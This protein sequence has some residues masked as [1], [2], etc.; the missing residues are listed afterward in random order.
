MQR[1]LVAAQ[2]CS[3]HKCCIMPWQRYAC[4]VSYRGSAYH[5]WQA[6][7]FQPDVPTVA[8]SVQAAFS[9]VFG[10]ANV[11]RVAGASRTDAGVH[12]LH[13]VFHV[14]VCRRLK[15]SG[16]E[17]APLPPH[18]LQA[19]VN[20]QLARAGQAVVL[21]GAT[22]VSAEFHARAHARM[23]T[24]VYSMSAP[25]RCDAIA[26]TPANELPSSA[27]RQGS[28]AAV[29]VDEP[30]PGLPEAPQDEAGEEAHGQG[31]RA[32]GCQAGQPHRRAEGTRSATR[33]AGM[34]QEHRHWKGSA[35]P[36]PLVD[37]FGPALTWMVR[38]SLDCQA[39][40]HASQAIVGT[41]DFTSFRAAG[42]QARTPVKTVASID[43][44]APAP[45]YGAQVWPLA[46]RDWHVPTRDAHSIAPNSMGLHPR[47][48]AG[49]GAPPHAAGSASQVEAAR[50]LS[51]LF[52]WQRF[53]RQPVF[54]VVRGPAFLYHQ[55]RN[56]AGC[57]YAVGSG[58]LDA[59]AVPALLAAC[60][61]TLLPATAPAHG[62]CLAHI[63]YD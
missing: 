57:L 46:L 2:R 47:Q 43:V 24:Y 59:T 6:H 40:Q 62:L 13:N 9:A 56:I 12:A 8:G 41:H 52:S 58:S 5:G 4:S 25:A 55:V 45:E 1:S 23:K 19:A 17:G 50:R 22:A 33:A 26:H 54:I 60:D 30:Q 31:S 44:I 20:H 42:C 36:P 38:K 48:H 14:D 49:M 27:A 51:W 35:A 18:Q 7:A 21:T 61:R 34:V 63:E 29:L 53:A 16:S 32:G 10:H 37:V 3:T 28:G 39:M 15:R 11:G